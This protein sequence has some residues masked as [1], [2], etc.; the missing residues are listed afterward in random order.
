[1]KILFLGGTGF[2][3]RSFKSFIKKEKE[4]NIVVNY[5]GRSNKSFFNDNFINYNQINKIKKKEYSHLIH[6]AHAST[7]RKNLSEADRFK[8]SINTTI[9]LL[10]LCKKKNIDKFIYISSGIVYH[11]L[12]G[13]NDINDRISRA[14]SEKNYKN[15]KI[16]CEKLV[17]NFCKNNQIN[18]TIL[19]CFSF[20]GKLQKNK[21]YAIPNLIGQFKKKNHPKIFIDGTGKDIRSF[22]HQKDLAR[23][24][25]KVIKSKKK[26]TFYNVG[27]TERISIKDL[28]KKIKKIMKSRKKIIILKNKKNITKY[29]PKK[30]LTSD[31]WDNKFI[32]LDQALKEII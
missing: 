5:V 11:D 29:A 24:I 6:C 23:S 16:I 14:N 10:K 8:S 18:Y 19:R 15:S 28:A 31:L 7:N 2:F 17:K 12:N 21:R 4:I 27:S 25:L 3:G 26:N 9:K 30:N 1:M 13:K 22:M 32:K 20:C